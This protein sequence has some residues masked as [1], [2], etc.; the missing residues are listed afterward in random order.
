MAIF[1]V[2][3]RKQTLGFNAQV[4]LSPW[5]DRISLT[6]Q[7]SLNVTVKCWIRL[8]VLSNTSISNCLIY[9]LLCFSRACSWLIMEVFISLWNNKQ[10]RLIAKL[11]QLNRN[12][13][14]KN[15]LLMIGCHPPFLCLYVCA[16]AFMPDCNELVWCDKR[17]GRYTDGYGHCLID[18]RY[19]CS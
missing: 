4:L 2:W 16:F 6:M 3:G 14:Y 9:P 12:S 19:D 10:C 7:R 1:I 15:M 11:K 18:L 5:A 17:T 13:L 8:F